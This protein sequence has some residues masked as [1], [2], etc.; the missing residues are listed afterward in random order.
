MTGAPTLAVVGAIN[1]D[2]VVGGTPLP[3][4]G[5]TVVGVGLEQVDREVGPRLSHRDDHVALARDERLPTRLDAKHRLRAHRRSY[6]EP[7]PFEIGH[8][9]LPT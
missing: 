4:P 5:E 8:A 2:L 7:P 9:A 1:V 3:A 6:V